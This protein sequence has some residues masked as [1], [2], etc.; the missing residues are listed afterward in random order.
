MG[1]WRCR[2]RVSAGCNVDADFVEMMLHAL[3]VGALHDDCGPGL[4]FEA[5]SAELIVATDAEVL[6]LV[7]SCYILGSNA[8]P[9]SFLSGAH[10]ILKPDLYR[11]RAAELLERRD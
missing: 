9:L 5:N 11:H 8:G 6:D 2:Q 10:L 7:R 3:D 4:T 1:L